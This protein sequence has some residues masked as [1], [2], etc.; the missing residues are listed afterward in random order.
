LSGNSFQNSY[1]QNFLLPDHEL[2]K[3]VQ[4]TLSEC[5]I[6]ANQGQHCK[7]ENTLPNI[8]YSMITI[9]FKSWTG[10][11]QRGYSHQKNEE[12]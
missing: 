7:V 2:R 8:I 5:K 9:K 12:L 1:V 11:I 6:F 4:K 3:F 10:T